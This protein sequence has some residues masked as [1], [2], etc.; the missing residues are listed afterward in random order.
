MAFH[1]NSDPRLKEECLRGSNKNDMYMCK[2][3]YRQMKWIT[4]EEATRAQGQI[5]ALVIHGEDDGIIP[6]AAGQYLS[7]VLHAKLVVISEAS[8]QV[9]QEKSEEVAEAILTFLNQFGKL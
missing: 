3:W 7:D 6:L 4:P 8:H 2:A 5:P 9:M 1:K